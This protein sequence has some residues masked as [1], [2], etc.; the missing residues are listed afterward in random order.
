[1]PH[2]QAT[3]CY[4]FQT[5]SAWCTTQSASH[6][7]DSSQGSGIAP[8]LPYTFNAFHFSIAF[9]LAVD[10]LENPNF[11]ALEIVTPLRLPLFLY[12]FLIFRNTWSLSDVIKNAEAFCN[13]A[14]PL[15]SLTGTM[16]NRKLV[17]VW[18][19]ETRFAV[20]R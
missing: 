17:L 3:I 20:T 2:V 12:I 1:M 15:V 14:N 11:G 7:S 9:F 13:M 5:F 19:R 8:L 4:H 16:S 6:F 18:E 10:A